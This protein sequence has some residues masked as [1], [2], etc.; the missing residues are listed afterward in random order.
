MGAVQQLGEISQRQCM[1]CC[2]PELAV[3]QQILLMKFQR[4]RPPPHFQ[5]HV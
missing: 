1:L 5:Q 4:N 3:K 2:I